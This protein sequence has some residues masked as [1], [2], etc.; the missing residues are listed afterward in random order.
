[1]LGHVASIEV[2]ALIASIQHPIRRRDAETLAVLMSQATGEEA[3]LWGSSIVGYGRYQYRYASGREGSSPAAAFSPRKAA[4]AVYFADGV[5]AHASSLERLGQHK[6][7]VGCLY[8]NDL[9]QVNLEV[10]EGMIRASFAT[11]TAGTYTR[12][13]REGG[14]Q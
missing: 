6:T 2:I 4:T 8:I 14:Q 3:A 9:T 13:A 1:M 12:R 11:L 7:G 5:G 10:L